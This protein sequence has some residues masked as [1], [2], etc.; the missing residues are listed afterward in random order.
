[1]H[2]IEIF[3]SPQCSYCERAKALLTARGASFINRDISAAADREEFIRR[4]PRARS[5]PQIFIDSV[6][7]GGFEDL[8]ILDDNGRLDALLSGPG[9]AD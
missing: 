7:I 2:A 1:M 3:S 6:H 5:V 4:L 8:Q 9:S